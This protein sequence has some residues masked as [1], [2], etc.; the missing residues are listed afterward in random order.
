A[1]VHRVRRLCRPQGPERAVAFGDGRVETV[2]HPR[3]VD[4]EAMRVD[5]GERTD[6]RV[7]EVGEKKAADVPELR[8]EVP[9]G[10]KRLL[11]IRGIENDVRSET[12]AGDER[13]AEGV[14]S[15]ERDHVQWIHA[16]A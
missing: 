5:L 4:V 12:E 2:E 1:T 3:S 9:A 6:G 14:C 7:P 11:E 16:V 13:P 10:R 8:R 15:V